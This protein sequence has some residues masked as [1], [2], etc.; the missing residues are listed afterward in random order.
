MRVIVIMIASI[1]AA[2]S[3][4][5]G[6]IDV[7]WDANDLSCHKEEAEKSG[8]LGRCTHDNPHRCGTAKRICDA[9]STTRSRRAL[10]DA[11]ALASKKVKRD[12]A[13]IMVIFYMIVVFFIWYLVLQLCKWL[14]KLSAMVT[15]M[16]EDL[17]PET[18]V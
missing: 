12:D 16:P 17:G 8:L 7:D 4:R 15:V 10:N 2:T 11:A 1:L 18:V 6:G 14:R 3:A 9:E 5:V 13:G